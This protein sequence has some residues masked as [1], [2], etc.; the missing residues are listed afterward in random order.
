MMT[1]MV[2]DL[3]YLLLGAGACTLDC[4]TAYTELHEALEGFWGQ[5]IIRVPAAPGAEG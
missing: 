3:S 2:M 4:L 5:Y 1:A